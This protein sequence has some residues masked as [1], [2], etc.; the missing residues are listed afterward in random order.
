MIMNRA[1]TAFSAVVVFAMLCDPAP[2]QTVTGAILGTVTDSAGGAVSQAQVVITDENTGRK[3]ELATDNQGGYL[4]TFL[5]VGTYTV[6][7]EKPGFRKAS[8]TGTVLQVD[9]QVRLDV[10]LE[11]GAVSQEIT[12]AGAAPLLQ[13]EDASLGDV[14]DTR[15]VE[16]LPLNGRNFLQLA[17]LTPGVNNGG[18]L[19][20]GL[21]VN[22]GRGDFN[23]YLMDGTAN[24]S[25][26]DGSVVI[27]PNLD[28]IQ[29]F[30][31]QTSTYSAEFGFA[32]SGQINLVTKSGSN[33]FHGSAYEFLRNRKLD[34]RNFFDP[35][36]PGPSFK[37]NQ[38]GGTFGGPIRKNKTFFFV[39]YEGLR[40]RQSSTIQSLIP[41]QDMRS[42]NFRGLQPIFDVLTFNPSTGELQQFGDNQIPA[43]RIDKVAAGLNQYYPAPNLNDP[44]LNYINTTGSYS[45]SDEFAVRID[46]QLRANNQLFVRYNFDDAPSFSPAALPPLGT[47]NTPRPQLATVSD[48]HLLSP[49]VINELRLGFNRYRTGQVSARTFT[50]DIA[51]KLGVG[52]VSTDPLDFGFP[53]VSIVPNYTAVSDPANPFPTLRKDNVYQAADTVSVTRGAHAFKFG[54]QVNRVQVNGVQNSF[55]RGAFE[56]DGRFTRNPAISRSGNEFADYLLGYADKTQRQVGSTRVDMRSTYIGTFAQDDWKVSPRLTV[57]LGLRWEAN[58]PLADKYGRNSSVDWIYGSGRA[59]VV[60]PGQIGPVT[61]NHYND[62]MYL[63]DWN[64]FAPRVGFA[65]RPFAGNSTVV[66]GGYGIFYALSVGQIF[67]F[68]AQNPPRIV[69][70]VFTA[71]FPNPGLTFENGFQL[72]ALMPAGLI[73]VRALDFHRRDPYIQQWDLTIQRQ[74]VS[75]LVIELAYV[76]NKG[77]KLPRTDYIN[78]PAPGPGPIQPRRP[79]QGFATFIVREDRMVSIYNAFEFKANKRFSHGH[80]FL[81]SYTFGKSIDT[82]SGSFGGGGNN[83]DNAQDS[84]NIRAERGRSAQD[85]KHNFVLSYMY[86]LPFG[87]GKRFASTAPAV[88]EKAIGGWQIAGITTL[89]S[90]F[91]QT[92]LVAQDRCNCDRAG[93]MRADVVSGVNW[94]LDNPTPQQFFNTAAFRLPAQYSFGNAGR[95]VIDTPGT[96]NF[97]FSAMK[98]FRLRETHSLQFRAEFF[99]FF[100]HPLFNTP[101][102]NVD[103]TNFG[104]ISSARA[105]RQIQFGLRYQF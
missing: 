94:R 54:G 101:N 102:L 47:Y 9:Q 22:G 30:K 34:A 70:D 48:T 97:D 27:R 67:T 84:N 43:A 66:R 3:R 103:S 13:T 58:T 98:L 95:G 14:I 46:H 69:N 89:R 16:T 104:R 2:G 52:G 90:G 11:V 73:S 105:G 77:T 7:I 82:G 78:S 28:A 1:L 40:I 99:N 88:I 6:T 44:R 81:L 19:G 65:Y 79:F 35:A 36:G 83:S 92:P 60:T 4:A 100:N 5:P 17:T 39:D 63:P 23:N 37:Q 26:F 33:R 45:N 55:G 15:K 91:S 68:Q 76:G 12:V 85:A 38:F 56:F 75:D 25:R 71:V 51:G 32:G 20:N 18:L 93:R 24:S 41:T 59:A 62:A 10:S 87:R 57:N 80:S 50:A 96:N 49:R 72:G 64:D 86:E 21:S 42:G 53:N 29:E 31:V 74:I 8:F 61:G